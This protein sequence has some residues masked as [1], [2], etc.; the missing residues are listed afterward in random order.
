MT[1]GMNGC[2]LSQDLLRTL[3]NVSQ[4]IS[5]TRLQKEGSVDAA[6]PHSPGCTCVSVKWVLE[7][8]PHHE[9]GRSSRAGASPPRSRGLVEVPW[10]CPC[11]ERVEACSGLITT[12]VAGL[13]VRPDGFA[14]ATRQ[15]LIK[16]SS[17]V[18]WQTV[19]SFWLFMA[20]VYV[21]ISFSAITPLGCRF[22]EVRTMSL[23]PPP[24]P[25]PGTCTFPLTGNE[26]ICWQIN[27]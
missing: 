15:Y 9:V 25:V 22:Y 26:Y 6:A 27:T 13:E 7:V 24:S 12:A 20:F 2:S 3:W 17:S 21:T 11:G 14:V 19:P 8:M 1:T 16:S 10:D 4:M 23:C 5:A 18:S